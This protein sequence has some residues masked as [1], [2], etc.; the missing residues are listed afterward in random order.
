MN[1]NKR[2]S[3]F[4]LLAFLKH[5]FRAGITVFFVALPLCLGVALASGAPASSG[6]L[7]G[8]IGGLLIPLISKSELSVS[9]PAAGLT[10]IC[11]A[12][13]AELG[14]LEL[15]FLSVA[16]AGFLQILLGI[17]RLG[18]LTHFIPSA[19]IKGLL[20]AIG[21]LLLSKQV[22][23]L[24]GYDQPDFWTNELVNILTFNHTLQNIGS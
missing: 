16:L 20:A 5:D 17:C 1:F 14:S 15:L 4:Y 21:I 19:V 8:I 10:A 12:A 13:I 7:A 11:A 6:L 23:L 9:G 22:P 2:L 18:E 24:V 3:K